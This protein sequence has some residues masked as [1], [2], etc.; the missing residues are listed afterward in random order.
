VDLRTFALT[1]LAVGLAVLIGLYLRDRRRVDRRRRAGQEG[2][3]DLWTDGSRGAD[4][5][6][7]GGGGSDGGS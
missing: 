1:S 2:G 4:A 5:G 6:Y 3:P 7:D